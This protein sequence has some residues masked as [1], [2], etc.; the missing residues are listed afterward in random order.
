MTTFENINRNF[1]E[2]FADLSDGEGYLVLDN[3][4]DPFKGGLSIKARP[5]GKKMLRIEAMSG[6]EKSLTALAFVFAFQRYLPAPFYA[7]DEVDMF[8]DGVN[9]DKL[10]EM[11]RTQS[12]NAQ[13][14]VVSLRK[15]MLEK[16]NRTIGVIQRKDGISKITGVRLNDNTN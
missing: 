5:R 13:F 8:L 16:A 15:P 7:F 2:I 11:I 14:I 6:G 3:P 4:E 10:A 12:S 1:T 9:V